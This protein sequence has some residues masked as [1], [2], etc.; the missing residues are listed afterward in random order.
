VL[1]R[2][3]LAAAVLAALL[4]VST[5]VP[6]RRWR[7]GEM[8]VPP[9]LLVPGGPVVDVP[10]RVWIDTDAACGHARTTDPDDCLAIL[11]LART[12]GVELA[13]ISTVFGNA[14]LEVTDRVARDL[15]ALLRAEGVAVP[16]YRGAPMPAGARKGEGATDAGGSETP[17]EA[18]LAA[19]LEQ[20]LDG[21]PLTILCLGPLTNLELTLRRHPRLARGVDRLVAVMGRRPGHLFHPTEGHGA[22]A[23]LFGHGPVFRDLNLVEDPA[24][25]SAI[26]ARRLPTTLVPYEVARKVSVDSADLDRVAGAGRTETWVASRARQWLGFW[27]EDV[28]LEGFY[29]FDAVAALYVTDPGR[30]ACARVSAAVERDEVLGL[31]GRVIGRSTALL[32]RPFTDAAAARVLYCPGVDAADIHRLMLE[33]L[34]RASGGPGAPRSRSGRRPGRPPTGADRTAASPGRRG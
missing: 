26:L 21:A 14:P 33:R 5:A 20:A 28:G 4:I 12:P 7:T 8:P 11:L 22:G 23:I 10:R 1:R 6:V 32:V 15:A 13:G 29:P 30:F 3:A 9:L 25:A 34:S 16:V 31:V 27:R 2:L 19:A 17:A 18:A 24:A